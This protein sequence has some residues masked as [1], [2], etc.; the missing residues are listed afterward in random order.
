MFLIVMTLVATMKQ[1]KPGFEIDCFSQVN[2]YSGTKR[3]FEV[4]FGA[5]L[6]S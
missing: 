3:T 1:V 6:E 5:Q 4:S 2:D